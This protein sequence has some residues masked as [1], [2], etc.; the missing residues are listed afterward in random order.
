MINRKA[1]MLIKPCEIPNHSFLS[2]YQNGIGFADCYVC[3]VPGVISQTVF[4]EAFYTSP[5][6]K[7]E[8][9][10]LKYLAAKPAS[11]YDAKQLAQGQVKTFSAW[12]V[13]TQSNDELLLT[14]YTGRTRS[15]L[16]AVPINHE[17]S[18]TSTLLH[19]GSAVIAQTHSASQ[20][21]SMG[22]LFRAL[23]GFHRIY[24]HLLLRAACKRALKIIS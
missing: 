1:N 19:F 16:M 17:N 3:E 24:S 18:P 12:Q 9:T 22:F 20:K 14:D 11:D 8:R 23:L 6:F 2:K 21:P 4:I 7:I 13:E 5:L 10:I 15:W